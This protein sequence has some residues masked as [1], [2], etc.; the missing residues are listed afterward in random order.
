MKKLPKKLRP[1]G[2]VY[3]DMFKV[4][5]AVWDKESTRVKAL[6]HFGIKD[7][8]PAIPVLG[9]VARDPDAAGSWLYSMTITPEADTGTWAHEA[10][11]L[12]DFIMDTLDLPTG[13]KNTEVRA[14]MVGHIVEQIHT[15]MHHH[16]EPVEQAPT[17]Y[18]IN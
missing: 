2:V 17:N 8:A 7:A 11:H 15:I 10:V 1:I 4:Q 5:A 14:Y 9:T 3:I 16:Y 13:L 12:A 18:R 6:A